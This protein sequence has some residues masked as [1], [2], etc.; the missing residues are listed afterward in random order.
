MKMQISFD[1]D[2]A[3]FA[4]RDQVLTMA[5]WAVHELMRSLSEHVQ[6]LEPGKVWPLRGD[7]GERIGTA[8]IVEG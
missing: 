8:E 1:L 4:R 5:G 3:A 2:N 6:A 7:R